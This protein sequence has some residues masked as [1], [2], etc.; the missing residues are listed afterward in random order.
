MAKILDEAWYG[1]LQD[2]S[3]TVDETFALLEPTP[4]ELAVKREQ[5]ERS[6]YTESP[7]LYPSSDVIERL[8]APKEAFRALLSDIKTT[9]KNPLVRDEYIAYIDDALLNMEL[10]EAAARRDDTAYE[11]LNMRLYGRPDE[12]MHR[13]VVAW[14]R[15]DTEVSIADDTGL[16]RELGEK[17]LLQL[18]NTAGDT[19]IIIPSDDT[20]RKVR[21]LHFD[22]DGVYTQLFGENGLPSAEV[23]KQEEGDLICRQALDR[24]GAGNYEIA[25]APNVT[26]AVSRLPRRLYR[27]RGYQLTRN[28]FIGLV[29]HEIGSHILESINGARQPLR[30]LEMGLAGYLKGNEGRGLL[31]EQVVYESI[32]EAL[33][34]PAWEYCIMKHLAIS[35]VLGYGD[36]RYDFV[37][38]YDLLYGLYRF[39]RERRYPSHPINEEYSREHA[40]FLTVRI[41]KG[42]D[43]KG[44]CYQKDIV[45][46]EGI[47]GLWRLAAIS[48]DIIVLGDQGKFNLLDERQRKLFAS[49]HES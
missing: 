17:V 49:L 20:F 27:P 43:G 28:D 23:I 33:A 1:R 32:T 45:Y 16:L 22:N 9:E 29:G 13:A 39:W 31:R 30:L 46:L 26:W 11:A 19:R 7:S 44:G 34:Q 6:G 21:K 40:W 24:I 47:A 14:I 3:A 12:N 41:L 15:N 25:D 37:R 10:V 36:E 18:P 2:I 5:F 35:L 8:R 48:P 42:T 38:L 4:D